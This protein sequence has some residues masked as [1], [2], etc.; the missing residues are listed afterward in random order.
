MAY[1]CLVLVFTDGFVILLVLLSTRVK[2]LLDC[3]FCGPHIVGGAIAHVR[4]FPLSVSSWNSDI[5]IELYGPIF[6]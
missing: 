5:M 6:L 4:T 1:V 2:H 3:D